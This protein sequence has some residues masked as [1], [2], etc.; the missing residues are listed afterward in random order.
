MQNRQSE[1]FAILS[2]IVLPIY[3]RLRGS[4]Q[5]KPVGAAHGDTADEG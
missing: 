2:M 1:L 3:L 5:S 4:P